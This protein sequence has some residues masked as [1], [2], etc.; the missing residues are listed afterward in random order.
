M[1]ILGAGVLTGVINTLA[2]SGSLVTLPIFI[3]LC[4]LPAPVA[5]GT[6]RVGVMLQSLVGI[7]SFHRH[8]NLPLQGVAWLIGPSVGG[9][10]LGAWLAVDMSNE[11]MY[12]LIGFLMLFMLGVILLKPKRWL[13]PGTPDISRFKEPLTFVVFTLIG[14]YGGLIQ[15]G[16]GIF[17]LAALVLRGRFDLV[18]ANA[19]K[20]LLV[21]AFNIPAIIVFI[22]HDQVHWGYGLIMAAAQMV[23]AFIGARFANRVPNANV[24]IRYLLIVIIAAAAIKFFIR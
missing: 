5:N 10:F 12:R 15:A 11:L 2:G 6:N 24:Y 17:L 22:A 18:Q 7:I 19:V 20:M 13:K 4:G 3:F 16:T 8:G 21:F 23:G 9:A 1:I 14:L